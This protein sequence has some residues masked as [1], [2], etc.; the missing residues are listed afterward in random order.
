MLKVLFGSGLLALVVSLPAAAQSPDPGRLYGRVTTLDGASYEGYIRWGANEAG[1]FD[2]LHASKR[3]PERNRRVARELGWERV[4]EDRRIEIFGIGFSIPGDRV[5]MPTSSQ[6]GIR[7]GHISTLE[8]LSGSRARLILKSGQEQELE[9]GGDIGSSL[10]RIRVGDARGG[11]VEL[12]WRQV[13]SIDFMG[14]PPASQP[15]WGDRLHGT[16]HTRDGHSFTGYIAWDMDEVFTTDI[17][18]GK[19]DGRS[20]EIPFGQVRGIARY[21]S[22]ASLVV[23]DDGRELLLRGSNDVNSS[24]RDIMVADPALGEIRV[25]WAAFDRLEFS[26]P[27]TLM[28]YS[29]FDGGRPIRGTVTAHG[30]QT[31]TG[32]IRWDNDEEFTWEILDGRLADGVD[33]DIEFSAIAAIERASYRTSRVTLRDG[34][35]FELGNSNDVDENNKGLYIRRDAGGLVLVRWEDFERL[36]LE[37]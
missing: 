5:S 16:L 19:E 2:I 28:P 24:N 8:P 7:F 20:H 14:P 27:S 22:S 9:N 36:V 21:S 37:H 26:R 34:R 18:N 12:E 10:G 15:S 30:G 1:W 13:R 4:R 23:L 3:M 29:A 33:L 35:V 25:K 11:S 6:A 31:H 32:A 17:L